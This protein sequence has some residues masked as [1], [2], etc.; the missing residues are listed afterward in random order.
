MGVSGAGKSTIGQLLAKK[1]NWIFV[2]GD[3][4]HSSASKHKMTAGASL[5]D[6]DR[7]NWLY[8]LV[9]VCTTSTKPMV[10]SCSALKKSY[11]EILSSHKNRTIFIHLSGAKEV[12]ESRLHKRKNHFFN[13]ILLV[14]QLN[15]L[16]PLSTDECGFKINFN[17]GTNLVVA[18]IISRLNDWKI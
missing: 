2:E 18:E 17:R 15:T 10:I 9:S 7:K 11:R 4:F 12:L 14:D 1:M 6:A 5:D 3:D 8:K 16:E 13:P